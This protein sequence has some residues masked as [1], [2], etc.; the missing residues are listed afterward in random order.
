MKR[1]VSNPVIVVASLFG[2]LVVGGILWALI[3]HRLVE[4]PATP[5]PTPTPVAVATP[6]PSPSPEAVAP[7]PDK[8]VGRWTEATDAEVTL[9][10]ELDGK[11][12]KILEP[13]DL[14]GS[15]ALAGRSYQNGARKLELTDSN[16]LVVTTEVKP[17]DVETRLF[18]SAGTPAPAATPTATDT[19]AEETPT[20][21]ETPSETPAETATPADSPTE[22][23]PVASPAAADGTPEAALARYYEAINAD[24]FEEAYKLRSARSRQ[25]TTY[26]E[27]THIWSN[28]RA[29]Q[30]LDATATLPDDE[31]AD[32]KIHLR[33]EDFNRRSHKMETTVYEG[34]VKMVLEDDEWRYDGG[35]FKA[36]PASH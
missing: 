25:S 31:H 2:L 33:A 28:N 1:G 36:G 24:Q 10:I 16:E 3:G 8:L 5:T 17:G 13:E 29:I 6:A 19:P 15:Y 30:M 20:P 22:P 9:V 18:S 14:A 27:F 23:P 26:P 4:A 11:G 12:V 7:A 35:D 32:L 34:N 21:A